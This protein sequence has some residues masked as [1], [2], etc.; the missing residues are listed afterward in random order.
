MMKST[1]HLMKNTLLLAGGSI[2]LRSVGLCFQAYLA[3]NINPELLG[4]FGLVSSVYIVFSTIS[5]SGVRFSVTRLTAEEAAIG[6]EYPRRLIRSAFFYAFLFGSFSMLS[7]YFSSQLLAS[8]WIG[9]DGATLPLRIMAFSMPFI[10]FG[11]VFE[12]YFTA[13]QKVFRIVFAQIT[14]Q[15]VRISIIVYAFSFIEGAKNHPCDVL[16]AGN[17]F[18]EAIYSLLLFILYFFDVCGKKSQVAQK[19]AFSRLFKVAMPLAVSAYMRTGLSSLG[20]I[21]I[22]R[23]LKKAGMAA[24]GAFVTYGIIHQMAFPV[25]MFPAALLSALGEVLVPRLTHSQVKN[26][27]VG[28][29]YIVNRALRIGTIFSIG[30]FGLMFFY[31]DAL[32]TFIYKNSRAGFYIRMFAPLIP[33]M[34]VDNITDGC[35]KGLRQQLYSMAFNVMEAILNITLLLFLLPKYAIS[36]YIFTMYVKEIFNAVLSLRRLKK[37][38]SVEIEYKTIFYLLLSSF[39]AKILTGIVAGSQAV[40]SAMVYLFFYGAVIYITNKITRDDINWIFKAF[41]PL[42]SKGDTI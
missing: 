40:L 3:R 13:K 35:L 5:I 26:Q 29:C 2:L 12:G 16:S 37:V 20:H 6:N 31:A 10:A 1:A 11:G 4:I 21:I 33:I 18:G 19:P 36:G 24:S 15:I 9:N 39:A 38:T 7:M 34:Y 22:P 32:G 42:T 27:K 28:I 41:S 17:L 30:I 25:I 14:N 23:G 8:F